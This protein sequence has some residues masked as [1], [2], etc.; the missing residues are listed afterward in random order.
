MSDDSILLVDDEA[1][2]IAAIKRA[3]IDEACQIYS[4]QSAVEAMGII[5]CNPIKVVISDEMMPGITGAEFLSMVR[6]QYPNIVRIMLTGHASI[7]SAI[8]AINGGE[9]YR[10][11]TKPWDDMDLRFAVRAAIDK[12]NLEDENRRLL[13]L[14][15]KQ[16]LNFKLLERQF[17]G[18]TKLE[19]DDAGRIILNDMSKEDLEQIM[20]QYEEE[21]DDTSLLQS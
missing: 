11:F 14:V 20:A 1:N 5:K 16:A 6:D 19:R 21:L 3:F 8:K 12:Y 7:D 4:A 17:P 2:V 9:I 10:F 18:I 15:R 13:Y